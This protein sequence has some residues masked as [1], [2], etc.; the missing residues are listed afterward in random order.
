MHLGA[1]QPLEIDRHQQR[2]DLIIR[3][4]PLRVVEDQLA[5][6]LRL[7]A[8][9]IPFA[10]DQSGYDH[11]GAVG[12][13][14]G[15]VTSYSESKCALFSICLQECCSP[16]RMLAPKRPPTTWRLAT[17][18]TS[19]S[20]LPLRCS[21]TRKRSSWIRRTTRRSGRHRDPMSIL[22]LSKKTTK[23]AK[24]TSRTL[25]STRVARWRLIPVTPKGTSTWLA[26]LARTRCRKVPKRASNSPAMSGRTR[27][28]AS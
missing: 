24:A 8:A 23:H 1:I 5:D 13:V 20:T 16:P 9:P 4:L 17:K 27:W 2:R 7:E 26:R 14:V 3:Y 25:S 10:F 21:T 6:L 22:V 12:V 15:N 18:N 11:L 19:P 28:T